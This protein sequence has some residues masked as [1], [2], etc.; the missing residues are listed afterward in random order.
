MLLY[1]FLDDWTEAPLAS[2]VSSDQR[3]SSA[4]YVL[5]AALLCGCFGNVAH[6]RR[7]GGERAPYSHSGP[8]SFPRFACSTH[9]CNHGHGAPGAR[10]CCTS[11]R[12][13]GTGGQLCIDAG[14]THVEGLDAENADEGSL[15][16]RKLVVDAVVVELGEVGVRPG[17]RGERVALRVEGADGVD[18]V[19]NACVS[20][21]CSEGSH[22]GGIG[23][24]GLLPARTVDAVVVVTLGR[25]VS[26]ASAS[27]AAIV[28]S[29][30]RRGTAQRVA[31]LLLT[32]KKKVALP[33]LSLLTTSI[34]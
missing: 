29:P 31:M 11:R 7:G 15:E 16:L 3:K 9:S 8:F 10:G 32:L 34:S 12:G 17:V 33:P 22:T 26:S 5:V 25:M 13:D 21:D 6:A 28:P 19:C 24:S 23:A 1:V 18:V 20:D 4:G 14:V 27:G 2:P 30:P